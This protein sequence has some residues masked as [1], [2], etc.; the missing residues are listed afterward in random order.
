MVVIVTCTNT[1][2]QIKNKGANVV[3]TLFINFSNA[4]GQLIP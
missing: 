4:Q 3:T 2:D 1:E